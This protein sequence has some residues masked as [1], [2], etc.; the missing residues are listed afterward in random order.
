[1]TTTTNPNW[2]LSID[3]RADLRDGADPT[4]IA[5]E[6]LALGAQ[7]DAPWVDV[8]TAVIDGIEVT[9]DTADSLLDKWTLACEAAWIAQANQ[10]GYAAHDWDPAANTESDARHNDAIAADLGWDA[11]RA[12]QDIIESHMQVWDTVTL[13]EFSTVA[14]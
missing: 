4:F 11:D 12:E 14:R 1:M 13:P 7:V 9:T 10:L 3:M 8:T 5:L 6:D 2:I